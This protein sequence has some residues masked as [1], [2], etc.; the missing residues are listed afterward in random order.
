ML[1]VSLHRLL[2]EWRIIAPFLPSQ[3]TLVLGNLHAGGTGKTPI[4]LWLLEKLQPHTEHLAYVSRG[5]GRKTKETR[6]VHPDDTAEEVGDEA[7]MVRRHFGHSNDVD[8]VVAH[9]RREAFPLLPP[10]CPV[11]LDDAL[12]HWDLKAPVS[13][14]ICPYGKWYTQEKVLPAGPLREAPSAAERAS[15]VL[16][17]RCPYP[18]DAQEK[19][20]ISQELGLG[21]H[22]KLFA[23]QEI[24]GEPLPVWGAPT[25]R[26]DET[27]LVFSGIGEPAEFEAYST[28]ADRFPQGGVAAV[29]LRFEDH[30]ELNEAQCLSIAEAAFHAGCNALLTTSKDLAR[31]TAKPKAWAQLNVY[32][33]PHEADMGAD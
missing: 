6:I 21:K 1:G 8:V 3:P 11:L 10:K 33:I 9:R 19:W 22:Q 13:L 30:Q 24:M 7:L 31:L 16:I 2:Y 27:A 23:A 28:H 18:L 17:T 15:A 4:A 29:T 5:Y 26:G 14:L 12:Q 32:R 25:W 20:R